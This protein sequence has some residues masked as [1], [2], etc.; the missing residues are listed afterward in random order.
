MTSDIDNVDRTIFPYVILNPNE[1][2]YNGNVG[3][4]NTNL[5]INEDELFCAHCGIPMVNAVILVKL[6]FRNIN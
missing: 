3:M 2:V 4:I 6:S 5:E 1:Y